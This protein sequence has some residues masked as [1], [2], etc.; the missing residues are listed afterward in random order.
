[1]ALHDPALIKSHAANQRAAA[2][3][4]VPDYVIAEFEA[5]TPAQRRYRY[6]IAEFEAIRFDVLAGRAGHP[7]NDYHRQS[8]DNNRQTAAALKAI[9][10]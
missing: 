8:A 7:D 5:M 2:L 1:M 10:L 6:G 3:A 4:N 9:G